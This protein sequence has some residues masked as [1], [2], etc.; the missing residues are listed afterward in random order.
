ML[1]DIPEEFVEDFMQML[2]NQLSELHL[3]LTSAQMD[4]FE[5]Q[6]KLNELLQVRKEVEDLAQR[7]ENQNK[8]INDLIKA[9]GSKAKN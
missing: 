9:K 3:D 1:V 2:I 8:T 4:A 7:N 5:A 6:K